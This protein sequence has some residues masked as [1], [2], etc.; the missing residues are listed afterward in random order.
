MRHPG[1]DMVSFTGSVAYRR[2]DRGRPAVSSSSPCVLELGGKSAAIVL[3]DAKL[4]DALPV[5]IGAQRRHS[6]PA[7]AASR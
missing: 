1:V 2:Q 6:T 5:L 7:R 3:D 4:E